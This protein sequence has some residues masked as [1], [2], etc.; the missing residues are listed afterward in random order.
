MAVV[1]PVELAPGVTLWREYLTRPRQTE[2]VDEVMQLSLVAPFYRPLMPRS[3]KPFSVEETN[4]GTLGWISEVTG[5]R[6]SPV[7]P[8]TG[9]VWPPIP[10]ALLELWRAIARIFLF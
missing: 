10:E 2:L 7:H 5:Y 9:E 1:K 6:Y 8:L 4:F 3:G